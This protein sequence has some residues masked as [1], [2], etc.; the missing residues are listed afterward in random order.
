M[1]HR[2]LIQAKKSFPDG[3][4]RLLEFFWLDNVVLR[5]YPNGPPGL[6]KQ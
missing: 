4:K 6:F 1:N 2:S 5:I 3:L